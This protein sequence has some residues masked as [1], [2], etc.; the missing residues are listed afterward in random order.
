MTSKKLVHKSMTYKP[1]STLYLNIC[2]VICEHPNRVKTWFVDCFENDFYL[3]NVF[4]FKLPILKLM[5]RA[6]RNKFERVAKI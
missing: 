5:L 1:G 6:K 2:D 4:R 3:T